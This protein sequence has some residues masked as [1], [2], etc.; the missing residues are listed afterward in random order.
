M[1]VTGGHRRRGGGVPS[2]PVLRLLN[3]SSLSSLSSPLPTPSSTVLLVT[4]ELEALL[5]RMAELHGTRGFVRAACCEVL[6]A[7]ARER[8][9]LIAA[10]K[11]D[12]SSLRST[13]ENTP[14][15]ARFLCNA[16]ARHAPDPEVTTA[17]LGAITPLIQL[18]LLFMH[19]HSA[20]AE[21]EATDTER[22]A[23]P[24]R[25]PPPLLL[26][27]ADLQSLELQIQ[28]AV[29][30]STSAAA[31]GAVHPQQ[32]AYIRELAHGALLGIGPCLPQAPSQSAQRRLPAR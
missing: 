14:R 27:A 15:A 12:S 4:S 13:E 31:G 2:C 26:P 21:A 8:L 7:V 19:A 17:A 6:A 20:A 22:A 30:E 11:L 24:P 3:P 18:H 23:A 29:A 32:L 9:R 28:R 5:W 1:V 25:P 16:L 10:G